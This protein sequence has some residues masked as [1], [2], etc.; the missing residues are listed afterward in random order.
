MTEDKKD[1]GSDFSDYARARPELPGKPD[2]NEKGTGSKLVRGCAIAL[3]IAA[4]IFLFIIGAC[5]IS[6][7]RW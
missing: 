1:E 7:S 6:F 2:A 3:G 4:L 5:F